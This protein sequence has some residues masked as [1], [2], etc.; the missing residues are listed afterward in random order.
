VRS[1]APSWW[2]VTPLSNMDRLFGAVKQS[3]ERTALGGSATVMQPGPGVLGHL[4]IGRSV[5]DG[6]LRAAPLPG[7]L[8]RWPRLMLPFDSERDG[9]R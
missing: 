1:S 4:Q 5:R 6:G 2:G 7:I 3:S 9:F 8:C